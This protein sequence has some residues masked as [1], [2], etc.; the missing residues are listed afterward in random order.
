MFLFLFPSKE[1]TESLKDTEAKRAESL[2]EILDKT[3]LELS[4][5]KEHEAEL[6]SKNTSLEI[7]LESVL[8]QEENFK[9]CSSD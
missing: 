9:V 6:L 7:Q 3:K 8:Q 5:V 2:K 1:S 4:K